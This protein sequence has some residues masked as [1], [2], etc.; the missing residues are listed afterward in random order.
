MSETSAPPLSSTPRTR[1]N[2]AKNRAGTDR[3]QLHRILDEALVCHLGLVLDGRPVVLP[4]GMG[5]DGETLYL[6]G[7]SGASSLLAAGAG[8][9]VCVTATLLDEVVY[10]RS[11][12]HHSMNYRSAVIYGRARAVTGR[13]A[14]LHGLRVLTE[15]LSPGSWDHARG[16]SAKELAGVA[17][18]ALPLDEASVKTRTGPPADDPADVAEQPAW[19]GRLPLRR[20][21]GEPVPAPDLAPGTPVPEHVRRRV[22]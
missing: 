6:H 1:L 8:A 19:A 2:R 13:D 10:A 7:S 16:P 9:E 22:R 20:S 17:V 12:Q 4:T 18:L 5:R 21:W 15:H 11:L 14:K 3:V